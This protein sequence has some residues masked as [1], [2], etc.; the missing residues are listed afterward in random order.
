MNTY[1]IHATD[2]IFVRATLH[3]ASVI[4]L[5]ISGIDSLT[6]LI[7][8][9]RHAGRHLEGLA[10]L[11]IRNLSQGWARTSFI[12]FYNRFPSHRHPTKSNPHCQPN[13]P[14]HP[15]AILIHS[16]LTHPRLTPPLLAPKAQPQ[17][18]HCV[19]GA[20]PK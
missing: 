7:G 19:E 8:E 18:P 3:G 2:R 16:R 15:P 11:F 9:I 20:S 17:P 10:N 5:S 13:L 6:A 1:P 4:E 14:L 12:K